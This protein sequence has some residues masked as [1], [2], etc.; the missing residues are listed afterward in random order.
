[1]RVTGADGADRGH[2]SYKA[3]KVSETKYIYKVKHRRYRHHRPQMPNTPKGRGG[4][5]V[6]EPSLS[7]PPHTHALTCGG[8]GWGLWQQQPGAANE[9]SRRSNFGSD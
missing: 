5:K 9:P 2:V 6:Q 3:W 7:V 1:M 4:S 8:Y